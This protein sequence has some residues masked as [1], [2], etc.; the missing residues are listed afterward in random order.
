MNPTNR[1]AATP[2]WLPVAAILGL[3]WNVFGFAQWL[4]KVQGTVGSMMETGLTLEQAQL[5]A[6]LPLWMDAAFALGV[7]GGALGCVLL[8]LRLPQARAV[9]ALSLAAYLVLYAGDIA[10][11]VFAVFGAPQVAILTIVVAIAAGLQWLSFRYLSPAPAL[12]NPL[13]RSQAVL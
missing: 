12:R 11:G 2:K 10:L 1:P 9:F 6:S 3:A 4:S 5:Y 8:L 7:L 13:S